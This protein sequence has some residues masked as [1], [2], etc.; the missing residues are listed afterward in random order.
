MIYGILLAAGSAK[1][2]GSNKLLYPLPDGTPIGIAAARNLK[3][4][5]EHIIV[6]V[7][8]DDTKITALLHAEGLTTIVS[9][10]AEK[11]MSTS[12]VTAIRA[13]KNADGWLVTLADMPWIKPQTISNIATMIEEG[14]DIAV[15][16]YNGHRGHP[17]GFSH[18]FLPDLLCLTGDKGASELLRTNS[19]L[20]MGFQSDDVGVLQ[21]VD[22]PRDVLSQ[23]E[24][25]SSY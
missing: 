10:H 19:H 21:D 8:P 20:L 23:S 7:R 6:V 14:A 1:R 22:R 11:G 15:P 25:I 9:K 16:Y 5:V 2:F 13:T 12:L 24:F 17:V 4:S 3:Q 18:K